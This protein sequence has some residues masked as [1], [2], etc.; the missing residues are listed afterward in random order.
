MWGK[1]WWLRV[2]GQEN[3][4]ILPETRTRIQLVVRLEGIKNALSRTYGDVVR[5]HTTQMAAALSY[6]FVLSLFPALI[7]LSAAVAYLPVPDLFG[8][9]LGLRARVIPTDR[10]GQLRRIHAD[11]VI[12][13]R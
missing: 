2:S 4:S 10:L 5:N 12:C 6:Y 3:F 8:Q 9:D 13:R 7:F 1:L 11:M